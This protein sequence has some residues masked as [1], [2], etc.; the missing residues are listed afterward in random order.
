MEVELFKQVI[1]ANA[2][3]T[4]VLECSAHG[5]LIAYANP[6][7]EELTGYS[8]TEL[9]GRDWR[10]FCGQQTDTAE[11]LRL[12][13]AMLEGNREHVALHSFRR[14]GS[15][16]WSEVHL[17]PMGK[18]K[19]GIGYFVAALH[20]LT[21][22]RH[23]CQRL[24]RCAYYDELTG[25]A[26]RH[27]LRDR[28]EQAVAHARRHAHGFAVIFID[29]DRFKVINDCFGHSVGDELLKHVGL[30]LAATL[31]AG[32]TAARLGGDEFVLLLP[33]VDD[34]AMASAT[35]DRINDALSQPI[36][37]EKRELEVSCSIG[38]SLFPQDGAD[39]S[40]LLRQA[41]HAMYVRKDATR[42]NSRIHSAT[43]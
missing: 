37:I 9:I 40:S 41:D 27:L 23:F 36:T 3:P 42:A 12:H 29:V 13:D 25:L 17:A 5:Q 8:A 30:R 28:L 10:L 34:T 16:L 15:A 32:D 19:N 26:N 33:G 38:C 7:L 43:R 20:D 24:E 4:L 18:I 22:L 1:E 11:V 35:V 21:P 14:D 31:R 39:G 6:A 2:S